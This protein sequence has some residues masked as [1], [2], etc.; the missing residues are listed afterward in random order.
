MMTGQAASGTVMDRE[1]HYPRDRVEL[2]LQIARETAR[3]SYPG[4]MS[5]GEKR[6]VKAGTKEKVESY[7]VKNFPLAHVYDDAARIA[8]IYD[9]WHE[10][11]A[12]ELGR[13][14]EEQDCLGRPSISGFAVGAK[15]LDTF[16]HQLTKYPWAQ[17]L[18]PQL[19]LPLDARVFW[20]FGKL[21]EYESIRKISKCISD[22]S[23]YAL[24]QQDYRYIEAT[25]WEFVTELNA[26]PG[27]EVQ[28]Q[29]R[30]ELNYL[31][32]WE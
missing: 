5:R 8:L 24:S 4:G 18:W 31:W 10:S 20:A 9:S 32:V 3:M 16:M 12:A 2:L 21:E 17:P 25:L 27:A 28:V 14:L 1:L 19:H 11:C 29:S 22:R 7:F 6:I 30:I 23:A 15:L 13:F 26:R